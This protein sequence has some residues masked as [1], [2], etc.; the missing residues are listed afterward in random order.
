MG[1]KEKTPIIDL[2]VKIT[3]SSEG[4]EWHVRNKKPLK[5]LR[6]ADN[7]EEFGMALTTFSA[8]SLQKMIDIDYVTGV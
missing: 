5:R 7:S 1:R 8:R 3:L 6:M 4:V 2:P